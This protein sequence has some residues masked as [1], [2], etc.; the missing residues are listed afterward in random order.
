MRRNDRLTRRDM[1]Q[2]ERD[3]RLAE[4]YRFAAAAGDADHFQLPEFVATTLATIC[5]AKSGPRGGGPQRPRSRIEGRRRAIYVARGLPSGPAAAGRSGPL[6][7]LVYAP[8][9]LGRS[10]ER[11]NPAKAETRGR[12][13]SPVQRVPRHRRLAVADNTLEIDVDDWSPSAT[14]KSG[15]PRF[16]LALGVF[17]VAAVS[18]QPAATAPPQGGTPATARPATGS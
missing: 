12:Q 7:L 1:P 16:L 9:P 14:R 10:I 15:P 13:G 17:W 3:R 5:Q 11:Q 2:A 6:V 4:M 8:L 18:E